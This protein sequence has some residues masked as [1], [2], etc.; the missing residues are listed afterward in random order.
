MQDYY[1]DKFDG[2]VR[3][4]FPLIY[5]KPDAY[6]GGREEIKEMRKQDFLRR[7]LDEKDF[8]IEGN[9]TPSGATSN[10]NASPSYGRSSPRTTITTLPSIVST[11]LTQNGHA[12]ATT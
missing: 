12:G 1:T 5:V 2:G 10:S 6:D 3:P 8:M 7:L 4:R 11:S 9:T